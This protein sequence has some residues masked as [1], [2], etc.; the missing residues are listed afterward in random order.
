MEVEEKLEKIRR[1]QDEVISELWHKQHGNKYQKIAE[2]LSKCKRGHGCG[3]DEKTHL[4]CD[5]MSE[6]EQKALYLYWASDYLQSI[7]FKIEWAMQDLKKSR[8]K[9]DKTVV[10]LEEFNNVL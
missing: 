3:C 4:I 5:A 9:R 7:G 2:L 1:M 10:A 8:D 6:R